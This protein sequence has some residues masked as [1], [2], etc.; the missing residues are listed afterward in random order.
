MNSVLLISRYFPPMFDVGGKRAY[1]FARYLPDSGWRPVVLTSPVPTRRPVDST[2]LELPEDAVLARK[3]MPSWWPEKVNRPSDP[4]VAKPVGG[5][6][7]GSALARAMAFAGRYVDIPVGEESV[8]APR[9]AM[10][11]KRLVDRHGIRAIWSTSSPYSNLVHGVAASRLTSLP[12]V[13]DLRDPWT[14]NFMQRERPG[15]VRSIERGSERALLAKADRVVL[16]CET[17]TELYRESYPELAD[18]FMTIRNAFDPADAPAAA[19]GEAGALSL[20][21]FGNCYGP[22]TLGGFLKAI[23]SLRE[24]GVVGAERVTIRNYGRIAARDLEL[25][26]QLGLDDVLQTETAVPYAEGLERLAGADRL[27]LLAYGSET[28]FLPAKLYDYLLVRRPILALSEPS[29]LT[30]IIDAVGAGTWVRPDDDAAL[31]AA[32]REA[33][34]GPRIEGPTAATVEPFGAP[35]TAAALAAVLDEITAHDSP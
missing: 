34:E 24:Q 23:A 8:L 11:A 4:T 5:T 15:W 32:L 14:P 10:E 18:R 17:A 16:T 29:E 13:L 22:R 28:A 33:L 35:R 19:Q 7:P 31:E 12:L 20:V 27:V 6:G 2:P 30:E 9:V 3:L 1:R 25:A 26:E 21:H